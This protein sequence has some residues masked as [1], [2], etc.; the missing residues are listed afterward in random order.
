M[1]KVEELQSAG[2]VGSILVNDAER[3]V[4]TAY[5]DF[6]VTEVTSEAAAD[7]YKYISSTR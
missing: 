5:L 7:L 6:P 1:V 4:T 2:A 3:S